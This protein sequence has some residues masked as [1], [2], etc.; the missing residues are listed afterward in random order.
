VHT[1]PE[2]DA[3]I[4]SL[5]DSLLAKVAP[6]I[7]FEPDWVMEMLYA[8]PL[9]TSVANSTALPNFYEIVRRNDSRFYHGVQ[10][11]QGR[12]PSTAAARLE[13]EVNTE[14]QS[15]MDTSEWIVYW[16]AETWTTAL[17]QLR[18]VL[19]LF[20]ESWVYID[21]GNAA[22]A[23]D[24][25]WWLKKLVLPDLVAHARCRRCNPLRGISLNVASFYSTEASTAAAEALLADHLN[26]DVLSQRPILKAL[27]DTSRNG[28]PFSQ[29]S[30]SEIDACRFDPPYADAGAVPEWSA[31]ASNDSQAELQ[32]RQRPPALSGRINHAVATS[33]Q[34]D[35]IDQVANH[36]VD[37]T[38]GRW[39][40]HNFTDRSALQSAAIDGFVWAK[41]LREA[42]GRLYPAGEHHD[43]LV[44]HTLECDEQCPLHVDERKPAC[45]CD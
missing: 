32:G 34:V 17:K 4:A 7:I 39:Q 45:R 29:R 1:W 3:N 25:Q 6:V 21:M 2:Y 16:H 5:S 13:P 24:M 27:V 23:L 19:A 28:G 18:K 10:N 36:A 37:A 15:G 44:M 30:L 38:R 41:P 35:K 12:T 31:S 9:N 20:P 43:C 22:Y 14:L 11:H 40:L 26:R 42:D 8:R 33:V